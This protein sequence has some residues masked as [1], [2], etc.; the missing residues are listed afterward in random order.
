MAGKW[1]VKE[2]RVRA[3]WRILLY[4]LL[5]ALVEIPG[6]L[7][8]SL[9]PRS[10]L[11][12][13]GYLLLT[14][15][16]LVAGWTVLVRFDRRPPGALGF[17]FTPATAR[18]ILGGFALGTGLIAAASA[19]L[20][21]TGSARFLPDTGTAPAYA[22]TLLFTLAFFLVAAAFEEVW[23]RG[24]V[25]QALV[26]ALGVWPAV[27]GTSTLFAMVHLGNPNVDAIAVFNI[28]LAG[29][30]LGFAYLR[31]RS[32]WFATALHAGW[33]WTMASA[34]GFPVSG[35]VLMDTPLYDAIETGADW[36]TGG[37]FGPEAGL[38]G[39][40]VLLAAIAWILRTGALREPPEMGALRPLVDARLQ[41]VAA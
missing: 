33:N 12:V 41:E 35:L 7:V 39:T 37:P 15:G 20:F 36:W 24:Y 4:L 30:L 9:L 1:L 27:V 21:L 22:R 23:F 17:A 6:M 14:A 40:A 8:A 13:V 10:P 32:L 19:L 26:E 25:L 28:F 2:G 5:L 18:E 3:G 34:I 38:A 29:V 11:D 31:T 16:G